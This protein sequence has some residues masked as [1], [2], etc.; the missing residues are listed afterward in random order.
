MKTI[1]RS[2][3]FAAV[4]AGFVYLIIKYQQQLGT[5]VNRCDGKTALAIIG[6]SAAAI[7]VDIIRVALLFKILG[8]SQPVLRFF[9][10]MTAATAVSYALGSKIGLGLRVHWQKKHCGIPYSVSAASMAVE[11]VFGYLFMAST[12]LLGLSFVKTP[13]P[14]AIV[15]IV[16]G[17][18]LFAVAG[19]ALV[20]YIPKQKDLPQNFFERLLDTLRGAFARFPLP[21]IAQCGLVL[22][23][24]FVLG[25]FFTAL[26]LHLQMACLGQRCDTFTIYIIDLF[27]YFV[28]S[29]WI[30]PAGFG[31]K[32]ATTALL[33]SNMSVPKDAALIFT[34][35][36]RI[37]TTGLSIL[38]GISCLPFLGH[39]QTKRNGAPK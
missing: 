39:K 12:I 8:F 23:L 7:L 20:R 16:F 32:E 6:L 3:L 4:L 31:A 13:L 33:L 36:D 27:S 9:V 29:F 15:V 21:V 1:L 2:F 26:R 35:A 10:V 34:V 14:K 17:I 37:I 30:L 25:A 28:S 18:A 24:C 5:F 11:T 22:L 19:F 38:I